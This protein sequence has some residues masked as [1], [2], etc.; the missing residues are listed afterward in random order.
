M[1][2]RRKEITQM[3][4][5][6]VNNNPCVKKWLNEKARKSKGT[7]RQYSNKIFHYFLWLRENKGIEEMQTLLDEHK[8]LKMEGREYEH[9][10]LVKDYLLNGKM[11]LKGLNT[12]NL[13]LSVIRSFYEDNECALPKKKI[14]LIITEVDS[15][16]VREKLALKPMTL[17]DVEK[18]ISPMKIRE[19]AEMVILLQSGMGEGEFVNQFNICKCRKEY[20]RRNGHVCEPSKIMKQLREGRERIKIVFVGRKKNRKPYFTFIGKDAVELLKRYLKFREALIIKAQDRLKVLEEKERSGK[21]LRKWEVDVLE[22]LRRKLQALT[23]QWSDG[24]P[25]FLSNML[26]PIDEQKI[27]RDVRAYKKLTGLM[28]REFTPHTFRDIFKT[29]CAHAGINDAMSEYFIGHSLD[30][31]DYNKLDKMYPEDFVKEYAKVEPALNIISHT[32][33]PKV[34]V[35]EMER[36]KEENVELR[37]KLE[38]LEK[39]VGVLSSM[40]PKMP[41]LDKQSL[42]TEE[43]PHPKS[44]LRLPES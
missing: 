23:P 17:R 21:T 7:A 24:Q 36:L 28:N 39:V 8:R 14:D 26:N 4:Q 42:E 13:A 31:L 16:R 29:E 12:R 38:R 11:A 30:P 43:T 35:D 34:S 40:I 32:G 3:E 15:Q 22:N 18:L 1:E 44:K 5:E 2:V 41:G 37:E 33:R 9:L 6:F 19:K 25:I 20:V 10:R 27:Q